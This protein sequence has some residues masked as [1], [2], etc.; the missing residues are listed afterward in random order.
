[1]G[2]A[3]NAP[4]AAPAAAAAAGPA[5]SAAVSSAASKGPQT[6]DDFGTLLYSLVLPL[7]PKRTG[8]I[9]SMLLDLYG[10]EL[11]HFLMDGDALRANVHEAMQVL[12]PALPLQQAQ[13][14]RQAQ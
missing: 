8:R 7:E 1:M 14:A 9:T 4:A 2:I 12:Q 13:Q 6:K 3:A 5:A 10:E 11:R